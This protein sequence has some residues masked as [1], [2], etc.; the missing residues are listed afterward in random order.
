[1]FYPDAHKWV[2]R[3]FGKPDSD[4]RQDLIERR[5]FWQVQGSVD[6]SS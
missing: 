2:L 6:G 1:M 5:M 3:G 4:P